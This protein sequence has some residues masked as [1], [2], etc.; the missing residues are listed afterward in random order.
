MRLKMNLKTIIRGEI[1]D[2]MLAKK[3][4]TR[5]VPYTERRL[6]E[7][8]KKAKSFFEDKDILITMADKR[9]VTV[10]MER[11]EYI[12]K[13][14]H[15]LSDSDTYEKIEKDPLIG[16]QKRTQGIM[17]RWN[18]SEF[19]PF[20]YHK[21]SLTQTD[22]NLARIYG[23]PK[24]YEDNI[25]LGPIVSC[26]NT[27]LHQFARLID[28]MIDS[29]VPKPASYIKSCRDFVMKV[30]GVVIPYEY[31]CVGFDAKSLFTNVSKHH[32][33]L[34]V[35]RRFELI[36]R[37]Y[38]IPLADF[39]GAIT[40][41]MDNTYFQFNGQFHKQKYGTPMGSPPSPRFADMRVEDLQ[42]ECLSKLHFK[43]LF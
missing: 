32:V 38:G 27:P 17:N 35:E 28:Q 4:R 26:V 20:K 21:K 43:P 7:S 2:S 23:L 8:V 19:F 37:K 39:M 33:Q 11:A 14:N 31:E 18:D 12:E 34:A 29:C 40:L 30:K 6:K 25:P 22:T 3:E 5:H 42:Q 10:A 24:I 13:M 41:L 9:N 15:S 36:Y 1:V 16:L